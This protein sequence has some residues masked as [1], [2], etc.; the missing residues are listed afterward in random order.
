VIIGPGLY[1][2]ICLGLVVLLRPPRIPPLS[3][4][5]ALGAAG[6]LLAAYVQG[7][8]YPNHWLPQAGLALAAAVPVLVLPGIARTRAILVACGLFVVV[9]CEIYYWTIRPDPAVA[10]AIEQHAPASP[11]IIA[12]SQQLTTG[13]PVTRNV[14]G[15]W[16]GSRAGQFTASGARLAGL[17]NDIASRAYRED[18]SAFVRDVQRNDPDLVLVHPDAKVSLMREPAIAAVMRGYQPASVLP[19]V[20]VWVRAERR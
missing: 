2:A 5:W 9:T 8:N 1:P 15:R 10:A 3:I 16:V 7:K 14:G 12:L 13:H 20:E 19:E 18:I 6:F 11:K 4:A 17:D